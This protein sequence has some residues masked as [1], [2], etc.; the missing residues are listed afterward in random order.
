MGKGL[1]KMSYSRGSKLPLIITRGRTR[2]TS[3]IIGAKF[4][5]ECNI[6]VKNHI[7]V[8]THWK[9][10]RQDPGLLCDFY[11][12]VAGK[13]AMDTKQSPVK[14]ACNKHLQNGIRQFR[15]NL[16]K[17]Y[18]DGIPLYEVPTESS[19]PSTTHDEWRQLVEHWKSPHNILINTI[20][21]NN[22]SKV[23]FHQ[24][25]GSR[26]YTAHV[27]NLGDSYTGKQP[28][29]VDL[30]RETHRYKVDHYSPAVELV[31]AEI[32]N[33]MSKPTPDGERKNETLVLS[34][35]LGNRIKKPM[36]LQNVGLEH[37]P[38]RSNM[39]TLADLLETER[40]GKAEL[41]DL[42]NSQN[43]NL[44]EL[45]RKAEYP[46]GVNPDAG[47][48]LA[49]RRSAAESTASEWIAGRGGTEPRA[50]LKGGV[51]GAG[52]DT[53]GAETG[54]AA[55]ADRSAIED[56]MDSVEASVIEV[57]GMQENVFP[58]L[59][60]DIIEWQ[61]DYPLIISVHHTRS[62]FYGHTSLS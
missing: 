2:P 12:K 10:Y 53:G 4:V 26:S 55:D 24:T 57:A 61:H 52:A 60:Q 5:S 46:T 22:R 25:T 1:I 17:R 14:G 41:Q 43:A 21:K 19:V 34:E 11:G 9:K 6:A 49:A 37:K 51:P 28:S 15:H 32:E 8:Y 23:R 45:N 35:F 33:E 62:T 38:T 42:V 40:R 54:A 44:F 7:P 27:E 36:F 47:A 50:G 39:S 59:E 30:F 20:N 18:F 48:C 31:L 16:K 29:L 13:F 56:D 58:I 3:A